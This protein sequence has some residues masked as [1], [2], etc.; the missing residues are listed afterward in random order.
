MIL[1]LI[2]INYIILVGLFLALNFWPWRGVTLT[3]DEN[4]TGIRLDRLVLPVN[5]I[6]LLLG[7]IS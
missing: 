5:K 4:V 6:S 3:G 2:Q 7:N 1:L